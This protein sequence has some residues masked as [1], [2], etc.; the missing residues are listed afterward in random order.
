VQTY[1]P[2]EID[3][4]LFLSFA[5]CSPANCSLGLVDREQ[6]RHIKRHAPA[7]G[8]EEICR[9]M[10]ASL[11]GWAW[12]RLRLKIAQI[13]E[14]TP[15]KRTADDKGRRRDETPWE[16]PSVQVVR[17]MQ[18]KVTAHLE[19]WRNAGGQQRARTGEQLDDL[20]QVS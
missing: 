18:A 12:S 4:C 16:L 10:K 13:H 6:H 7:R 3:R 11:A 5:G 15:K 20:A 2:R 19:A 9:R 17:T 14:A 8:G 1:I